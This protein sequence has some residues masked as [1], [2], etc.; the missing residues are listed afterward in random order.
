MRPV[1]RAGLDASRNSCSQSSRPGLVAIPVPGPGLDAC[2]AIG[3]THE[4]RSHT[5]PLPF[6]YGNPRGECVAMRSR[7][8]SGNH[9]SARRDPCRV[10][11]LVP[12]AFLKN[13]KSCR[14]R[15]QAPQP[16]PCPFPPGETGVTAGTP[17]PGSG[18]PFWTLLSKCQKCL[19]DLALRR[20][21]ICFRHRYAAQRIDLES[22]FLAGI[23]CD[24]QPATTNPAMLRFDLSLLHLGCDEEWVY[25]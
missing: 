20:L 5:A 2:A 4:T 11:W 16:T 23:R 21:L 15:V 9:A 8:A 6:R 18:Q 25:G 19:P 17:G 3:S 14:F 13:A 24:A 22:H 10:Y 12:G 1:F 7:Q